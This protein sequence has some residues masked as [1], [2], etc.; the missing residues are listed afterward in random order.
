MG[1]LLG[2]CSRRSNTLNSYF[3]GKVVWVTGAS[4]GFGE[5]LCVELCRA[6]KPQGVIL[7]ARRE[8][9]L[10][11]VKSMCSRLKPEVKIVVLPLDLAE[12]NSLSKKAKQA[13]E[14]FGRIDVLVNNGGVGFRGVASETDLDHDQRVMN[15]DYFSGVALVKALLPSWLEA[16]SGHV[17]QVASVQSFFGLP[18]RT[19]YSAAKHAAVGFYDSLRA[20]L[21][22]SGIAV[23]TICPGYIKTGH[24]LNAVRGSGGG[25][26]EGHTSK[27]V[28]PN[29]LA[30]EALTAIGNR[31]AELV[32]AAFDAKVAALL[33]VL[34]PSLLFAIM[35]RR[36]RKELKERAKELAVEAGKRD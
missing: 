32:S 27:G 7:S 10:E 8:G 34:C 18:G 16:R 4:G 31:R 15:V 36:A 1:S 33:R 14:S 24:S 25:Y 9:D 17:V 11:R 20:E 19:A 26:P 13:L 23:T 12:L 35:R 21:A 2:L 28:D 29:V 3:D 5:A 22:D 30:V 6:A